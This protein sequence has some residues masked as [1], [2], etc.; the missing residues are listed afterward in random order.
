MKKLYTV[1]ITL[2]LLLTVS[3]KKDKLE[4]QESNTPV[5][6]VSGTF[7]G[8]TLNM[9]A[10]DDG[11]YMHTMTAKEN[12]VNVFSGIISNGDL[13]IEVGVFDGNLD[14][15]LS[16]VPNT[17]IAPIYASISLVPLTTLSKNTFENSSVINSIRWFI[18]GIDRGTNDIAIYDAGVYD[19]CAEIHFE[20]GSDKTLC[21]EVIIGYN[22]NATC[23]LETNL[24]G[25]GIIKTSIENPS[26]PIANVEWYL[27]DVLSQTT[28]T[29]QLYLPAS[30]QKLTAKIYFQ[31][32]TVKTKSMIVNGYNSQKNIEDF[33]AFEMQSEAFTSRDFNLR[34]II[35]KNGIEYRSDKASNASSKL[36]I[37]EIKYYGVNDA[38][39]SVY[40]ISG[41]IGCKMRKAGTSTDVDLEM[42]VVFGIEIQ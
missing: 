6:S 10:G 17:N 31:N 3:C 25:N 21:N 42:N 16:A 5:F 20:D 29:F 32:G 12:G 9:I 15:Q 28:D 33:S 41:I 24:L 13:S 11:A 34:V 38:G 19:V 2:S 39:K 1:L 37:S 26:N 14:V 8:E 18:D 35:T 23:N 7:D 4:I 27:N 36:Y 40:K 22:H 30:H